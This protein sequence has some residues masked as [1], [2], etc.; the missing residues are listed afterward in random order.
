MTLT[1][2]P[3]DHPLTPGSPEW[4]ALITASQI[5]KICNLTPPDWGTRNSVWHEKRGTLPPQ[6]TNKAMQRG[7]DREAAVLAHYARLIGAESLT[8]SRTWISDS[9]PNH[10]ATPDAEI[11]DREL[12]HIVDAKT[13]ETVHLWGSEIPAYY[14]A[15][16]QWDMYVIGCD[17]AKIVAEG[18]FEWWNER[19]KVFEVPRD[20]AWIKFLVDEADRFTELLD[21]GIEPDAEYKSAREVEALRWKYPTITEGDAGVDIPDELAIPY[22]ASLAGVID[23]DEAKTAA[24]AHLLEFLKD[25]RKAM[26]NGVQLGSRRK[27]TPPTFAAARGLADKAHDLL[28]TKD[29]AA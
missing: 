25:D 16:I 18:P 28:T 12:Q 26:W 9:N 29:K 2:T 13:S 23:A 11:W 10:A 3:L 20:E 15:Q 22:L 27:G 14:T 19:P 6:K 7:T 4:L 21:M 8:P 17:L 5:P 24:T 1:G